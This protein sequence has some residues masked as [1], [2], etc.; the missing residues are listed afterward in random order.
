MESLQLIN[1]TPGI[2]YIDNRDSLY[3]NKYRF[4]ARI[5]CAGITMTWFCKTTN[6]VIALRNKHRRWK[7]SNETGVINFI[8]WK[9]NIDKKANPHTIRVEGNIGSVFSNDLNF[10]K[11]LETTGCTVDYTEV[12]QC[13]PT[14]TKYFVRQ[15][16]HKY[17]IYLKSKRVQNDFKGKLGD[18]INR[19][20]KTDTVITPSPALQ[21]WINFIPSSYSWQAWKTGYCSSQFF[22]DYNDESIITLFALIFDGMISKK[23]KLEK[24]P[25][26]V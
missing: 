26:P 19:Y 20:K 2:D 23:Y 11:T 9:N 16:K 6:E 8:N 3:Y 15:P 24:Q 7:E 14:G 5:H 22:I 10:L 4:R 21:H 13:I 12:N 25:D 17:R 18:F 1:K